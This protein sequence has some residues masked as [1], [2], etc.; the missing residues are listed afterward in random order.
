MQDPTPRPTAAAAADL[1]S[2]LDLLR[3][4]YRVL[5]H[6]FDE[7]ERALAAERAARASAVGELAGLLQRTEA[8]EREARELKASVHTRAA[9][10][11]SSLQRHQR[12]FAEPGVDSG[13]SSTG[14]GGSYQ[15]GMEW[16]DRILSHATLFSSAFSTS[17]DLHGGLAVPLA[18][19]QRLEQQ[20][21]LLSAHT[22]LV[23]S[24]ALEVREMEAAMVNSDVRARQELASARAVV[25]DREHGLAEESHH[26]A[27][28][29][30]LG[31]AA[32]IHAGEV[33]MAQQEGQQAA[34]AATQH[35]AAVRAAA[36]A[37]VDQYRS[38]AAA[39]QAHANY[40]SQHLKTLE[41]ELSACRIALNGQLPPCDVA[42]GPP[43][44]SDHRDGSPHFSPLLP[45]PRFDGVQDDAFAGT[46]LP[47]FLPMEASPTDIQPS[48]A[49][50]TVLATASSDGAAASRAGE[51]IRALA[52]PPPPRRQ[53]HAGGLEQDTC[54]P[55]E[56]DA[57][58]ILL[59][60]ELAAP[61][62]AAVATKAASFASSFVHTPP[63]S[64]ADASSHPDAVSVRAA[65]AA[66]M[67]LA[68]RL[69]V[70]TRA[71]G[72]A[73]IRTGAERY[74]LG[75]LHSKVLGAGSDNVEDK[76]LQA[77][78]GT[79]SFMRA[80]HIGVADTLTESSKYAE[81]KACLRRMSAFSSPDDK[82]ALISA[83]HSHL[84]ALLD[85]HD[86]AFVKLLALCMCKSRPPQLH[87]Q[88]EFA[89][90]FT[91]PERLWNAELGL[92][93]VMAR[94]ALQWLQI[95]DARAYA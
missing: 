60:S 63:P 29:A 66:L 19:Q 31:R 27:I 73:S 82:M 58:Y 90:R 39:A 10:A 67:A 49:S 14:G 89:L 83:C 9:S 34:A 74:L 35:V 50:P 86:P 47:A 22:D 38:A 36:A 40:L 78:L 42:D 71:F 65:L 46:S 76:V 18:V 15:R 68:R 94:A 5:K 13:G 41:V 43:G 17:L 51:R 52:A 23:Q 80:S 3:R 24:L 77:Q 44:V 48:T 69:K 57:S 75:L 37:E 61:H 88:L 56:V 11:H 53:Y 12:T 79:L 92:P 72:G 20:E 64:S 26:A 87:S 59:L 30:A 16:A 85:P 81:A 6:N 70:T 7:S 54:T 32:D 93:L 95:Q 28:E 8:A 2:K 62:A 45:A 1:S 33:L 4:A 91:N 55:R 21:Q 25:A 84:C